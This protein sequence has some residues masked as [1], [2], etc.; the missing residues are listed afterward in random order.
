M[1]LTL[2]HQAA[3]GSK[4][5]HNLR[6]NSCPLSSVH[7]VNPE[8]THTQP[9]KLTHQHGQKGDFKFLSWHCS[10]LS[11]SL[12]FNFELKHEETPEQNKLKSQPLRFK[13]QDLQNLCT[14]SPVFSLLLVTPPDTAAPRQRSGPMPGNLQGQGFEHF[15][16]QLKLGGLG[17]PLNCRIYECRVCGVGFG[18][19]GSGLVL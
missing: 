16:V 1:A 4:L 2:N 11:S 19:A 14:P 10:S 17:F 18:V 6:C 9:Q 3:K 5:D 15:A 7:L 8:S 13:T 12:G